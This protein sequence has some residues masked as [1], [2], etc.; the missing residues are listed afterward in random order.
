MSE[1]VRTEELGFAEDAGGSATRL[2]PPQQNE[3]LQTAGAHPLC[4]LLKKLWEEKQHGGVI[5]LHLANGALLVPDW[6]DEKISRLSHGV[7]AAQSAD[8]TVTITIVGW[9]TISRIV[10]RNVE[11]LPEGMF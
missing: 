9:D 3:V 10:V 2:P 11:G 8:G 1:V 7:F 4:N 5:E 6:F